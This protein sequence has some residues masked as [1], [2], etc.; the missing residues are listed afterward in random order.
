[1]NQIDNDNNRYEQHDEG[2][3]KRREIGN[4]SYHERYR[5]RNLGD[6]HHHHFEKIDHVVNNNCN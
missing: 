4:G 6:Q 1:M 2:N 3:Q 5:R